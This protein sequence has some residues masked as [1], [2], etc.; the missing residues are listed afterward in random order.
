[1]DVSLMEILHQC[2]SKRDAGGGEVGIGGQVGEHLLREGK[3]MRL[4]THGETRKGGNF[5][6][7]NK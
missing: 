4:R 2:K 6:N 1:M 7:E 3:G 5:W